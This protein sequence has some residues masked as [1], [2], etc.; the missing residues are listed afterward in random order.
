MLKPHGSVQCT[1]KTE[2]S[3]PNVNQKSM[4]LPGTGVLDS[5]YGPG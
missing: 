5:N 1:R 4:R 2:N 3:E